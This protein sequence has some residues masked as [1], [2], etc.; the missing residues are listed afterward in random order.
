MVSCFVVAFFS[1]VTFDRDIVV[2]ILNNETQ[3]TVGNRESPSAIEKEI[4]KYFEVSK[5]SK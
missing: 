5:S 1:N 3:K 4:E 2:F